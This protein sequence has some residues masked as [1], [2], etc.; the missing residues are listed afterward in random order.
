[1]TFSIVVPTVGRPSLST[2]LESLA[3]ASGP[4]PARIVLVDDRVDATPPLLASRVLAGWPAGR[5]EVLTTGGRGPA[6][7]RNAGW[8]AAS[9]EWVTF[10]DDDV[11]VTNRWLHD[12]HIDLRQAPTVAAV[13]GRIV[14]PLPCGRRPTDWERGTAGLASAR[15]IT[16]DIAYRRCVL[17]QLGGFDERFRRAFREDADLALRA[18]DAGYELRHGR[19]VTEH[20]VRPA[21]W[22]ASVGQQRGNADDVLMHRL[23]GPQWRRRA[24]APLGRR[25]MHVL[26]TAA[27]AAAVGA[28]VAGRK[29]PAGRAAAL[30]LALTGQFAW[31]RIAPGPRDRPEVVRM[32]ATSAVIPPVAVLHWVRGGWR[33][34]GIA[35]LARSRTI[36]AVLVDRDGTIV[37]DVPYNGDPDAVRAL[38]DVGS[39]LRR[40]RRAR[41]KIGVI[42]NQ[43]GVARGLI[44]A[45]QVAAVNARVDALLG[46]FDTWQVCPH[47]EG[48]G[49]RCRKPQPGLVE[50]AA[51]AMGVAAGHCVV[52]GDTGADVAA[53]TAAGAAAS[54]LV[55]NEATRPEEVAAAAT[56][57][58]SFTRAVDGI[59]ARFTVG[60]GCT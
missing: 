60:G 2:L 36:E 11:R 45:E 9:G 28:T 1:M 4:R 16:A 54:V 22:H 18:Q 59:L 3:A 32:L 39:A 29:R 48:D 53:G 5:L 21:P 12:L 38:A 46:P 13:Q 23:H 34:R 41:V 24:R 20:P 26:T 17:E 37:H 50:A 43:S 49:C 40:L 10:L 57:A 47:G 8:R 14:V 33:Y 56:T 35:R 15:W 44:D 31:A 42:T 6:A 7:A 52:I 30:W 25:P 51:A 58:T 55:P 19:R 27:L